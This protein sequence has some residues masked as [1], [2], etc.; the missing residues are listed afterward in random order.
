MKYLVMLKN[1]LAKYALKSATLLTIAV[2]L[3][4]FK[5]GVVFYEIA[6]LLVGIFV[7]LNWPSIKAAIKEF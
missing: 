2:L 7:G 5:N 4:I 6:W 3:F 1:W